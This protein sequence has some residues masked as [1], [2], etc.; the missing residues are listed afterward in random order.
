MVGDDLVHG[1]PNCTCIVNVQCVDLREG[2]GIL[3]CD[4]SNSHVTIR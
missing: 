2:G 1:L 3:S 4:C